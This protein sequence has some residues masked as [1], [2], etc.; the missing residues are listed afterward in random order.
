MVVRFNIDE[1]IV[2]GIIAH[3]P[4]QNTNCRRFLQGNYHNTFA[5]K[6]NSLKLWKELF[7]YYLFLCTFR[8]TL[9]L[10]LCVMFWWPL[11]SKHVNHQ[12]Y[13][14]ICQSSICLSTF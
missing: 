6:C 5:F 1:L 13:R 12:R 7:V 14:V 9:L 4:S 11:K 2:L 10:K 3:L 8:V